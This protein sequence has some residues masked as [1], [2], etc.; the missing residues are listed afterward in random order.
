MQSGYVQVKGGTIMGMS[1]VYH[2][3]KKADLTCEHC[4]YHEPTEY[5]IPQ[6]RPHVK[7]RS[8][9]PA[10]T[11]NHA[12]GETAVTEY[13]YVP[14][15]DVWLQDMDKFNDLDRLQV[16]LFDNNTNDINTGEVVDI[17]GHIHVV[18]T[19]DNLNSRP[20]S[21]LFSDELVYTKRNEITLTRLN[22]NKIKRWKLEKENQGKNVIDELVSLMVPE[23]LGMDHIKKGL[24]I[25][26]ANAGLRNQ[27]GEFPE[28]QRVNGLLI[29]DPG[30]AKSALAKKSIALVPKSQSVSG[31]AVSGVSLTAVINKEPGGAMSLM[32]G[33]LALAKNSICMINELG[34]LKL[35]QQ[36]ALFDVMEEGII[37]TVK[38]GFP[39]N[40]ECHASVLA[41]ANPLNNKWRH[42]DKVGAEEFP[43]LLQVI[44]RFDLI[45]VVREI[46][47]E[48]FLQD[49]VSTRRAVAENYAKGAYDKD[50][51]FLQKYI[52]LARGFKP[53][54]SHEADILLDH[55]FR[56]MAKKDVGGIFRKV[57]SLYRVSIAIARL[58]L[59]DVVDTEDARETMQIFQFMLKEYN[60][61]V[62]IPREP[63]DVV[64]QLVREIVKD[65]YNISNGIEFTEAIKKACERDSL[66]M[67][68]LGKDGKIET[69]R[70]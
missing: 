9:C 68:Y 69:N 14:T 41:T 64:Y 20:E 57:E 44:D 2:M 54:I 43:L 50:K 12:M 4:N 22:I 62:G 58:K 13:E 36:P 23:V 15:V 16:K 7:P 19:N 67:G 11:K 48:R 70:N 39:G 52:A 35:D 56:G 55:F 42:E 26:E 8:R 30:T 10:W 21:V 34:R 27:E 40:V 47:E 63:R 51:T 28:R 53:K 37:N 3:F 32:L 25:M 6:Y 33:P 31:Q 46:R 38:Y 45:F 66:A 24:L 29:G 65:T 61:L 59:K 60:Q 49:Y 17:I 18:R 1:T 5:E